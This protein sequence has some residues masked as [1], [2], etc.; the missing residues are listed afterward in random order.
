MSTITVK[1]IDRRE[2]YYSDSTAVQDFLSSEVIAVVLRWKTGKKGMKEGYLG[3][4]LKVQ[5]RPSLRRPIEI[6]RRFK[7]LR[8]PHGRH[9]SA[10]LLRYPSK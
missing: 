5:P 7:G 4:I 10:S 3:K 6:A 1:L 8:F 9:V 2:R